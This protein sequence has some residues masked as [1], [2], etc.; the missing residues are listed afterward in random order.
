MEVSIPYSFITSSL[1]AGQSPSYS[2]SR[3]PSS[4]SFAPGSHRR[5]HLNLQQQT[6][7]LAPLTPKYPIDPADYSAYYDPTTSELHTSASISHISGRPSPNG[8]LSNSRRS[9]ATS[10]TRLNREAKS[11]VSI[12]LPDDN[13]NTL[14]GPSA[15]SGALTSQGFGHVLKPTQKRRT[16][17]IIPLPRR[18]SCSRLQHDHLKRVSR[19]LSALL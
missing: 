13:S 10:R 6:L 17:M 11:S 18:H 9:R 16:I 8:I 7:S 1:T 15:P 5:S 2:L 19:T 3:T 12:V 4:S 14:Q